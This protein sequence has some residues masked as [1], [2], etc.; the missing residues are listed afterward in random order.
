MEIT[1]LALT[2]PEES[3][4]SHLRNAEDE[5]GVAE[6]SEGGPFLGERSS[7]DGKWQ[8]VSWSSSTDLSDFIKQSCLNER[9]KINI[10]PESPAEGK[11][12]EEGRAATEVEKEGLTM[13]VVIPSFASRTTYLRARLLKLTKELDQ[14]TKQKKA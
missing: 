8:E 1:Y 9:F 14:T 10:K 4:D 12:G 2:G 11:G 13:E 7:R 3:I 6:R 5:E